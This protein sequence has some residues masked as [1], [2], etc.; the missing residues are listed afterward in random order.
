MPG[1]MALLLIIFIL[2]LFGT[3]VTARDHPFLLF[4]E[5]GETPGYQLR[6]T[7]PWSGWEESILDAADASLSRD[8]SENLG[9]YDRLPYR[10]QFASELGYK[11]KLLAIAKA[12]DGEIEARV[13]PTMVP[14]AH[15]ISKVDGVFNAVYVE[16]DAVGSTLYYGRG[17]G[18]M[19]TGSAVVADIVDIGRNIISGGSQRHAGIPGAGKPLHSGQGNC[20][21]TSLCPAGVL[22]LRF[23]NVRI[24][25][26]AGEGSL[27]TVMP[28]PSSPER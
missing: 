8:F 18:D 1:K 5:I 19:P 27:H 11:V 21:T 28:G 24:L 20:Y 22:L 3:P 4:H 2:F 16:G 14:T 23:R 13:H 26:P 10:G 17:A 25:P 15:L 7:A 9:D 12:A 6:T